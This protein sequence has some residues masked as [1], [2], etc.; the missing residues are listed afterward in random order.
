MS[1]MITSKLIINMKIFTQREMLEEGF[2]DLTKSAL[3][4]GKV[5]GQAATKAVAPELYNQVSSD[6]NTIKQIGSDVV[7]AFQN[8]IKKLTK[9]YEDAGWTNIR[10]SPY[11]KNY[12]L[13]GKNPQGQDKVVMY[14]KNFNLLE[15]P[16]RIRNST[17]T[18][19][20]QNPPQQ[21]RTSVRTTR[22]P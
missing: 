14:D 1:L 3:K 15:D 19:I 5:L 8:P 21:K 18:T 16:S 7:G 9:T 17:Q 20:S 12:K 6:Y 2:W 13:I 11:N 10:I 22:R 4:A